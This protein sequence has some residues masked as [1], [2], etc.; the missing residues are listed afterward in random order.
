MHVGHRSRLGIHTPHAP[1]VRDDDRLR[2]TNRLRPGL[3]ANSNGPIQVK[4]RE[5]L[6]LPGPFPQSLEPFIALIGKLHAQRMVP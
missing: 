3:G 2:F 5:C 1:P 6:W 4:C